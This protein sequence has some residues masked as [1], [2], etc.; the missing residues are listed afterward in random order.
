MRFD[1]EGNLLPYDEEEEEEVVH[2]LS[3]DEKP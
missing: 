2:T 3:Y 1:D